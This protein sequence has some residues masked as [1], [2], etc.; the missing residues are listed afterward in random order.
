M[1]LKFGAAKEIVCF[2]LEMIGVHSRD[3]WWRKSR[4][5]LLFK[6]L[7]KKY[8]DLQTFTPQKSNID[9][10]QSQFFKGIATFSKP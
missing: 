3:S 1:C 5:I 4:N 7:S 10:K 2:L 6:I 9:A 8:M